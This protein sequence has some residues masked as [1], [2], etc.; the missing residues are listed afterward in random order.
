M[1]PV[2]IRVSVGALPMWSD[3]MSAFGPGWL[4]LHCVGQRGLLAGASLS[5]A[6]ED[7]PW[8]SITRCSSGWTWPR[9]A[10]PWRWPRRAAGRGSLP[11]RDRLRRGEH[12]SPLGQA[13]EAARAVALL[14]RGR[15][16]RLRPILA[17]YHAGTPVR[18]HEH[19]GSEL[20]IQQSPQLVGQ[21]QF[22]IGREVT[23]ASGRGTIRTGPLRTRTGSPSWVARC[24][25]LPGGAVGCLPHS[26]RLPHPVQHRLMRRQYPPQRGFPFVARLGDALVHFL[27]PR[28]HLLG[29]AG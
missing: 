23:N 10:M 22:E 13:G 7:E 24:G 9:R 11:R 21:P 2:L 8:S 18:C 26:L 25:S 28:R 15:S 6:Q 29:Q 16:D 14:L 5:S 1:R 3:R 19:A 20:F 27:D 4:V 12:T 17:A